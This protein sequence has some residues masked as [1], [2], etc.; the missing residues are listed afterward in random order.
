MTDFR[1]A[2]GRGV[3]RW[4]IPL[5][6]L[7]GHALLALQPELRLCVPLLIGV[8][9]VVTVALAAAVCGPIAVPRSPVAILAV[10]LLLRL[11]FLFHPPQLSDDVYRYVWDETRTVAGVNPYAH[12][13]GAVTPSDEL[14]EIHSRINHPQFPTIYPPA[15]QLIFAAGAALH[16]SV[17][18]LKAVLVALDL[19]FCY[20]LLV[21]LQRVG[22]PAGRA[23]LYAWNPLPVLEIAGSGHV[24]GAGVAL[25]A[26]ALLL[27]LPEGGD[28]ARCRWWRY[29][30]AGALAAVAAL[31][32]LFPLALTPVLI[33]LVPR[34]WRPVFA[35]TFVTTM[36]LLIAAFL[37]DLANLVFSLKQYALNWEFAG[38]AFTVLRGVLGSGPAARLFLIGAFAATVAIVTWRVQVGRCE[39]AGER[40]RALAGVESCY[41]VAFAFLVLTP[42]LQPWY[43]LWLAGFLPFCGGPAGIVLCWAV[44]LTYRVQIPYFILGEWTESGYVTFAVAAAPLIAG[45]AA[46]CAARRKGGRAFLLRGSQDGS[47]GNGTLALWERLSRRD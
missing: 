26:A 35:A 1:V 21:L 23:V 20:A 7:G 46:F 13:P 24:D 29:A 10:A 33:L 36:G 17:V 30:G 32:K 6:V 27:L 18:A 8:T 19:L 22:L 39:A 15:A 5:L 43:A 31:V 9:A 38:G 44:L 16:P 28:G 34:R 47:I 14:R 2:P 45:I 4:G 25:T 41:C 11:M 3:V 42:T 37:P 12:A 40:D